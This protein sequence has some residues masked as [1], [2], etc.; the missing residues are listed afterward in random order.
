MGGLYENGRIPL[1]SLVIF[2]SGFDQ[3]E[4]EPTFQGMWVHA[5][6]PATYARHVELVKRVEARTGKT[7]QIS[8]GWGAYRPFEIQ[9]LAREKY[10]IGAAWPGTSSHGG[11]WEDQNTMAMDY[12]NWGEAYNWDFDAF[13]ADC[14]SVGL[15]AGLIMPNRG[16]PTEQ[17]H[18]VDLAPW[19][20]VP[21]FPDTYSKE[22][23]TDMRVIAGPGGAQKFADEFGADDI[24]NYFYVPNGPEGSP[25]W[26]DNIHAAWLLGGKPEGEANTDNPWYFDLARHQANARWAQKR[27]EIVTDVTKALSPFL[28]K[29]GEALAGL[30]SEAVREAIEEGLSSVVLP[31][32]EISEEDKADIARLSADELKNRL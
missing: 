6:S 3:S 13:T 2:N 7:L 19:S 21:S 14:A 26:V 15:T 32:V 31:S 30:S 10:G 24:G 23:E 27:G 9:V 5:L 17:W 11:Y 29:I 18:V 28:E 22:S 1:E 16:Y 8:S 20:A 4:W 12:S 25:S